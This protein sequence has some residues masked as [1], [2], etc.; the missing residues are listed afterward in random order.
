MDFYNVRN[1]IQEKRCFI[2]SDGKIFFDK[3]EAI[4]YEGDIYVAE[5]LSKG[6]TCKYCFWEE[7]GLCYNEDGKNKAENICAG[8]RK[9]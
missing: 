2:A 6:Y 8:F 7:G 9:G 3:D 5:I 1:R 4:K